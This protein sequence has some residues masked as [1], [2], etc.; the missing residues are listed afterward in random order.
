MKKMSKKFINRN[1]K[2]IGE[3]NDYA[4]KH[5]RVLSAI[6]NGATIIMTIAGDEKFNEASRAMVVRRKRRNIVEAHKRGRSWTIRPLVEA[7]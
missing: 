6:P 7:K 1:V 5:Q 4:F 2:L 3:F